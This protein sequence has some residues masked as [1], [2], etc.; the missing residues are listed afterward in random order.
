MMELE[1]NIALMGAGKS[2]TNEGNNG[3]EYKHH[4]TSFSR[5]SIS[6]QTYVCVTILGKFLV[7]S[8]ILGT[9]LTKFI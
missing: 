6:S 1:A 4:W 9:N 2:N 7:N 3:E 5:L 8:V